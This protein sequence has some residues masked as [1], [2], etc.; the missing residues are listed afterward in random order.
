MTFRFVEPGSPVSV[1]T[2]INGVST[3]RHPQATDSNAVYNLA[4]QRV[5]DDVSQLGQLPKG[6]YITGGRKIFNR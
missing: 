5:A 2:Y 1:V 6:I 4:G 3:D